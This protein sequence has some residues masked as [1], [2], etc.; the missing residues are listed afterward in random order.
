MH[1]IAGVG[2]EGIEVHH[3]ERRIQVLGGPLQLGHRTSLNPAMAEAADFT[4]G[5]DATCALTSAPFLG[6]SV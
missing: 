6:S 1:Q 2:V 3:G 4:S 5:Q